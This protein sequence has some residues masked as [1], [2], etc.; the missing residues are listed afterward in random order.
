MP[1]PD[2]AGKSAVQVRFHFVGR[3][4]DYW[5]LDNA[6]VGDRTCDPTPGG[7]VVGQVADKNTGAPVNGATVT[8][9]D[10]PTQSTITQATPND[11]NLGDGFF[12]LYSPSGTHTFTAAQDN[13]SSQDLSVNVASDS[14]TDGE[15]SLPAPRIETTSGSVGATVDWQGKTTRTVTIK[16]T[17]TAPV[18][19]QIGRQPGDTLP[20]GQGAPLQRIKGHYAPPQPQPGKAPSPAKPAATP[21]AAPWTAVADYPTA[22][23]DNAAGTIDGKVYSVGGWDS[24]RWSQTAAGYVYDP[25]TQAWSRLPDMSVARQSPQAVALGG[26][27]YVF[28]GWGSDGNAVTTTE[29]YDPATNTWTTGAKDPKPYATSGAGVIGNKI[30]LVGGIATSGA[31][32]SDVEVYD[33]ASNLWTSAHDYPDAVGLLGC[34]GIGGHLY[35]AGGTTNSSSSSHAYSYDPLS[36]S[37]SPIADLPIDLW[38]S[39]SAAEGGRL[40]VSGGVTENSTILTNQGFAYDPSTDTWTALPNANNALYR[41]AS[42]CGFYA[43]GGTTDGFDGVT[44]AQM[45][46]G[47]GQCTDTSS[48]PWMSIDTSKVTLQPGASADITATL[49]ANVAAITQPGTYTALLTVSAQSPYKVAPVPVTFTVNPPKTWGKITG[50]VTGVGCS[51]TPA[52]LPGA[53]VEI[54][55]GKTDYTLRTDKNGQY[56]LWLDTRNNPLTLIALKDGWTPQTTSAKIV[57]RKTTTVDFALKSS[58]TC[59]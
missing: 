34:G 38:G 27:L 52:P 13:Y 37:W 2:A 50:T 49:D 33:P 24:S 36:D 20:A 45:L 58:Q 12:W 9:A 22:I 10:Q 31:P 26:K 43:I 29:I 8:P 41:S 6:F 17:G 25:A 28:G 54:T 19:A 23:Q 4:A 47:Y 30:Y 39:N 57:E 21:F 48:V 18:T 35:C 3:F 11:P 15:F 1:L 46:P 14:A 40:L 16:N 59:S 32:A 53:T 55:A 42:A 5:E 56:V 51:G 7:L 44:S